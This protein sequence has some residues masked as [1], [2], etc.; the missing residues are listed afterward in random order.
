MRNMLR[1]WPHEVRLARQPHREG[2]MRNSLHAGPR[3]QE[4]P[5]GKKNAS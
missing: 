1:S 2:Q 3:G 5:T 4:S